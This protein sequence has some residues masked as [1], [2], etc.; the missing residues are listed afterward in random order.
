MGTRL[1]WEEAL[2][3]K[4][5]D[6]KVSK[7][8][9][10]SRKEETV[11]PTGGFRCFPKQAAVSYADGEFRGPVSGGLEGNGVLKQGG[12]EKQAGESVCR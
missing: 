11:I 10:I 5:N 9:Y 6:R 4:E 1:S 2:L 7:C 3:Q 12:R 8:R